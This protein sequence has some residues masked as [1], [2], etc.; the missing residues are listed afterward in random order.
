MHGAFPGLVML[1]K[2]MRRGRTFCRDHAFERREPMA[3]VGFSG[4]GIAGGL[5][6]LDFL[7]KHRGPLGPGKEIFFVQ[8]QRHCKRM[9]FPGCAKDR[10]VLIAGNARKRLRDATSGFRFN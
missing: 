8:R 4:I 1:L 10:T 5:G 3:V 6:F 2:R 7:T 9:G